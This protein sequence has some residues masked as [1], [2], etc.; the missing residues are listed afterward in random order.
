M[1]RSRFYK[2]SHMMND[3]CLYKG[4]PVL[5]LCYISRSRACLLS[6]EDIIIM[7]EVGI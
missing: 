6:R 7:N 5:T 3:Y 2:D 4:I 1:G